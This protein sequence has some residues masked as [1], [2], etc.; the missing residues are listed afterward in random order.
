MIEGLLGKKIGMCQCFTE[1][2]RAEATT[3]VEAGPCVVLQVK[4]ADKEGYN[5]VQI[6]F[7]KDKNIGKCQKGQCKE[8]GDFRYLRE[9]RLDDIQ[10]IKVGD[11]LNTEMFKAGDK[12][13]VS[14]TSKGKGF[15]G[16]VKRYNFKGGPKTHGQS[17]RHRAPGSAG[18]GTSPGRVIKGKK[19][20]GQMGNEKVTVRH[21]EIFKTVPEQNLILIKGALPGAENEL[22]IIKKSRK[23]GK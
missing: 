17:D 6:G 1:S 13:N 4:T 8:M 5:A 22:L 9:L 12:V 18:A 14:G 7:G 23:S 16:T 21:L 11:T 10:D 2:G 19:M 15:A 3:V 20:P